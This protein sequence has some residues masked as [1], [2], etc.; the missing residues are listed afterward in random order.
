M[1]PGR[2]ASSIAKV[3]SLGHEDEASPNVDILDLRAEKKE[4]L[5][6]RAGDN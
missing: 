6:E 2:K 4:I 5:R 3:L 1:R